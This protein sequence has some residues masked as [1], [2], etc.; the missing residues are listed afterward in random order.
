MSKCQKSFRKDMQK[1]LVFKNLLPAF[2]GFFA[3]T[4]IELLF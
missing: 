3:Y 4:V 2:S 1:S